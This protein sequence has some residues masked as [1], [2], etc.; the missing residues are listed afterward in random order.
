MVPQS[1]VTGPVAG[2]SGVVSVP[3]WHCQFSF[4][5][6]Y[7]ETISEEDATNV[8]HLALPLFPH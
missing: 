4:V 5:F 8:H 3:A 6:Y 2:A 1:A 7:T